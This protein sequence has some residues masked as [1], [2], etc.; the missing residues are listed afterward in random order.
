MERKRDRDCL[1]NKRNALLQ[2]H[3]NI[4]PFLNGLRGS[5]LYYP[6]AEYRWLSLTTSQP[7]SQIDIQ[8]Y[9][10]SKIDYRMSANVF[11]D[12]PLSNAQ[13]QQDYALQAIKNVN[14]AVVAGAPQGPSPDNGGDNPPGALADLKRRNAPFSYNNTIGYVLIIVTCLLDIATL[15]FLVSA[16]R[17]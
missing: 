6:T 10:K 7:I 13:I 11:Q 1:A 9:W 8:V 12:M 3:K 5:I 14:D 16:E 2:P 4:A 15:D 17:R